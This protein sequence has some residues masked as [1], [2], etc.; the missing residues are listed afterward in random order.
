LLAAAA[1]LWVPPSGHAAW[2]FL[3]C[4]LVG[5]GSGA[6]VKSLVGQ[7]A[8]PWMAVA[9]G[10]GCALILVGAA[11]SFSV[12]FAAIVAASAVIAAGASMSG[13]PLPG[14]AAA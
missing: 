14:A 5:L 6:V 10:T 1:G 3:A 7:A 2:T 11:A 4:A 9:L 8:R 12:P 13:R